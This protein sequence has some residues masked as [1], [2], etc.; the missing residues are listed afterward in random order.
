MIESQVGTHSVAALFAR[1]FGAEPVVIASAP[2]RVNLIGEHT[3]YNGGEVLPIG[4]EHRTYVAVAPGTSG[5]SRA[6]SLNLR[7][8]G[9]FDAAMPVRGGDWWDYVSGVAGALSARVPFLGTLDIAVASGVPAGAGLSSSA[10]REVA[11]AVALQTLADTHAVMRDVALLAQR[12]ESEF[13]GVECGIMDQFASALSAVDMALHIWCDT[14]ETE[15]VPMRQAVLIFDTGIPRTLR[16]S[17]YNERRAECNRA[18]ML[19]RRAE[20][21]LHALA[22]AT[23]EQVRDAH[24]PPP[25]DRRARHVVEETRRVRD[26][27]RALEQ[28][29]ELPGDLALASHASL[30]DLYECSTPELDWF[31]HRAMHAHGVRGARLTGAGWGGCAIAF[32]SRDSLAA[33]APEIAAD[34]ERTFGHSART[35]ITTAHGGARVEH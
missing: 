22:H 23:P 2:G 14:G 28:T 12:V 24:L 32:G 13:V 29:G 31:V 7:G 34:Y 33:A 4:I 35:W 20:P 9:R 27:V 5:A 1:H 19:L 26:S 15:L 30:R 11:S 18:L 3:D 17:A 21:G 16:G 10:A 8:E 25:L 6:V